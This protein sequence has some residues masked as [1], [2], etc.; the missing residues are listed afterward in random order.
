MHE[1]LTYPM[2]QLPQQMIDDGGGI[3]RRLAPFF[4]SKAMWLGFAVPVIT[5]SLSGLNHFW[6][7]VPEFRQVGGLRLFNNT[8]HLGFYFKPAYLGFFYLVDLNIL[9]SIWFFYLLCKFQDGVFKILGIANTEKLSV[10]EYSQSAD[11]T[12]QMTG[13]VIVFVLYGMWI[14]RGHI[15]AVARKAWNPSEGTDDGEELLKYRTAVIGFLASLVFCGIWLW[16]SGVPAVTLPILLI[17]S[18]IFFTLVARVVTTAGVATARSPIV[19]AFFIISGL[20]TS[21]LGAKGLV[22]LNFTFIWQGESQLS[23][24]VATSNGLKPRREDPRAEGPP[25]LGADAR[26]RGHLPRLGLDD[27]EARLHVRRH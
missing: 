10:Y 9:F 24:M 3:G 1:R 20:G 27:P 26:P 16:R 25:V 23:A 2:M 21:I 7:E 5:L 14:A 8:I 17:V 22:A 12:H 4:R 19:P 15:L 18:L 13:A 11:L 6:P